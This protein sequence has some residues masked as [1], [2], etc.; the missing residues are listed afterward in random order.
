M[1]SIRFLTDW[2]HHLLAQ[3]R[4]QSK[5]RQFD[6]RTTKEVKQQRGG[7]EYPQEVAYHSVA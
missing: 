1:R 5:E 4:D 2:Q 3:L 7:D 6:H